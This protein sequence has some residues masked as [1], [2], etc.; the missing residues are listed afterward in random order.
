M[1]VLTVLKV[2]T[3]RQVYLHDDFATLSI[4][5]AQQLDLQVGLVLP[6]ESD[7]HVQPA[8]LIRGQLTCM[9]NLSKFDRHGNF[10]LPGQCHLHVQAACLVEVVLPSRTPPGRDPLRLLLVG[11]FDL[12]GNYENVADLDILTELTD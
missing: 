6:T 3:A 8:C 7:R 9:T 1:T 10:A 5:P 12:R 2:L 11:Q 4:L